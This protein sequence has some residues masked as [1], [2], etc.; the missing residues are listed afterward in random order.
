MPAS[1][2]HRWLWASS[3]RPPKQILEPCSPN[4]A[5][6]GFAKDSD[7]VSRSPPSMSSTAFSIFYR[8]SPSAKGIASRSTCP[9]TCPC[10]ITPI[11][12]YPQISE[13]KKGT[14]SM[15]RKALLVLLVASLCVATATAQLGAPVYDATN[16][17]NAL[18]RY[19]ELQQQ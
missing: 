14:T 2:A 13:G 18:L 3:A 12:N 4:R 16:Y 7:R 8:P 17:A 1:S 6:I 11:T 9:T 5:P 19:F 15:K 10:P